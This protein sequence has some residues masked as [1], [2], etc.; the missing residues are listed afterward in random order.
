MRPS[1]L[2][3]MRSANSTRSARFLSE[4]SW[5]LA[6]QLPE[7]IT[8]V[9]AELRPIQADITTLEVDAIVNA[10]NSSLL[11][12]GDCRR[13]DEIVP[14]AGTLSDFDGHFLLFFAG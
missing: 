14:V 8:S 9:N 10:A 4:T 2:D 7:P 6:E 1:F 11:G 12:G 13:Y 3:S 5:S